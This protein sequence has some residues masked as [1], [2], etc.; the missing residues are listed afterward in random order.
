MKTQISKGYSR[1]YKSNYIEKIFA[2]KYL[3]L[4]LAPGVLYFILFE[5]RAMYGLL[6]AFKDYNARLG[7]MGSPFVGLKHFKSMFSD[8][9]FWDIREHILVPLNMGK[10]ELNITLEL[11]EEAEGAV[12]KIFLLDYLEEGFIPL[13][14]GL[15][16]S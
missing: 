11:P 15:T 4:L 6:L 2:S 9:Y 12:L 10:G 1:L 16:I 13:H 7:V 5:Y 14:P 3:Y 8:P